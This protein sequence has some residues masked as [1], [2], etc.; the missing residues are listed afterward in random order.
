A[1]D[2]PT[3]VFMLISI[4]LIFPVMIGYNLYQYYIFRGKVGAAAHQEG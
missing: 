2:T 4:G 3:L 1:S